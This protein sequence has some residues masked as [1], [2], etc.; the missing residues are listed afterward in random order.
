MALCRVFGMIEQEFD[1]RDIPLTR[2]AA[3]EAA[4]EMSKHQDML[5]ADVDKSQTALRVHERTDPH[6]A[7]A[8]AE[9][10]IDIDDERNSRP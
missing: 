2:V 8:A 3:Y 4:V 7:G 9:R 6:E 10:A 5:Q 1:D